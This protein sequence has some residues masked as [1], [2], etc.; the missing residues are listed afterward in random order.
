MKTKRM[1]RLFRFLLIVLGAGAGV[2]LAVVARR[3]F[4]SIFPNIEMKAWLVSAFDVGLAVIGGAVALAFSDRIM[5]WW[6]G[7]QS[8]IEKRLDKMPISQVMPSIIG[9]ILGLIVAA[10]LSGMLQFMGTG[11]FTTALSALLYLVLGTIGFR[12]GRK[13][14][15]EVVS[16]MTGLSGA[17]NRGAKKTAARAAISGKLLDTS[18][19]IDGR[20]LA[21]VKAG[22]IEGTLTVPRFVADELRTVADSSDPV[23]RERGRRGTEMLGAL[24][25]A[26]QN[27]LAIEDTDYPEVTDVDVKLLRLARDTGRT[28]VTC[29][30]NLARS[31]AVN[32]VSVMNINDLANAMRS[33]VL[34]GQDM[35][36]SVVKEGRGA[37]QGVAYTEDGTMIVIEGGR[38]HLGEELDITVT[39]VLQ[40]SAGRMIFAKL[41]E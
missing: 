13:R 29:D 11:M 16:M 38:R 17:K 30:Y 37:G 20:V 34:Q 23:K 27:R 4:A 39:S 28:V 40:T 2:A 33:A 12:I 5:A 36:V 24:R 3:I 32:S 18:A 15:R 25:E 9:L 22:F 31:A 35:R 26:L 21:I 41:K 10:L 8:E 14:S 1:T 7:R 19:I 6:N